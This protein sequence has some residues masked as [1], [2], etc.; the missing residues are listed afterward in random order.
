MSKCDDVVGSQ[1]S[2]Y[3]RTE[4]YKRKWNERRQGKTCGVDLEL[5][6]FLKYI[7]ICSSSAEKV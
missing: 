7:Y 2:Y 4:I 5:D 3:G 1:D 6:V